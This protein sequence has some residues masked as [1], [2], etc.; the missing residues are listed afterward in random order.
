MAIEVENS[1]DCEQVRLD[2]LKQRRRISAAFGPS[3]VLRQR[4]RREMQSA[5][6]LNES[7]CE[8]ARLLQVRRTDVGVE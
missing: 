8:S 1:D 5:S 3:L 2:G 6:V 7:V 4:N